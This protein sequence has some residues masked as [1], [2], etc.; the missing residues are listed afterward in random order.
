ML[1][2]FLHSFIYFTLVDT[3]RCSTLLILLWFLA[4]SGRVLRFET[5]SQMLPL[6]PDLVLTEQDTAASAFSHGDI[7]LSLGSVL[8]LNP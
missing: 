3:P 1:C 8:F 4:E 5:G 6:C 7:S 2:E